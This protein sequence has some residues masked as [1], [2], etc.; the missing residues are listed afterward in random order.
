MES[1]SMSDPTSYASMC[2]STAQA[3]N[4][5]QQNAANAQAQMQQVL[6]L[7]DDPSW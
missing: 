2:Q 5:D 4:Q 7:G 3:M 1:V 6:Q